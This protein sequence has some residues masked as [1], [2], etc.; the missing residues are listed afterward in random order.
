M[1]PYH[2]AC[3][4]G[5]FQPLHKGHAYLIAQALE[6]CD[7]VLVFVGSSQA[8][9]ET[10]NPFSYE[11]REAMLREVFGYH[12]DVAPLPDLGLGDVH[13]WGDHVIAEAKR[14]GHEVDAFVLGEE[15]KNDN[16][17]SP[18]VRKTFSLLQINRQ[19]IPISA[20][21]IRKALREGDEKTFREFMP[22][23]L[24]KHFAEYR[25]IIRA[26]EQ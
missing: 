24:H 11:E 6:Q 14:R 13:A 15:L 26:V 5:R 10:R 8:S 23:S 3:I 9:R 7:R 25:Q 22:E 19:G 18:E 4:L 21:A 17:F 16:W 12:I 2:D 1:K 20:T